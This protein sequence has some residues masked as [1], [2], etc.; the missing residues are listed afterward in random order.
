MRAGC[1][2]ATCVR[3]AL[4]AATCGVTRARCGSRCVVGID[5]GGKGK[6]RGEKRRNCDGK[7][8]RRAPRR[9]APPRPLRKQAGNFSSGYARRGKRARARA[10]PSLKTTIANTI[11]W[12][13][14]ERR[15]GDC[16]AGIMRRITRIYDL[17]LG[18]AGRAR[19]IIEREETRRSAFFS[20]GAFGS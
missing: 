5:I 8:G 14:D 12:V 18:S 2:S 17:F 6:R 9:S 3:W 16:V 7:M 10:G 11:S 1:A 20:R 19:T 4:S 15:L 13:N